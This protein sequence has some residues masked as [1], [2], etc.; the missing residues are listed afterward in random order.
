MEPTCVRVRVK[1]SLRF[2]HQTLQPMSVDRFSDTG[3]YTYCLS[4]PGLQQQQRQHNYDGYKDDD[5]SD[6]GAVVVEADDDDDSD[7]DDD[8]ASM[9]I[10]N[11][12]TEQ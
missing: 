10:D 6:G 1:L 7:N 9:H 4:K 12:D 11:D 2:E 5:S 8:N 3:C